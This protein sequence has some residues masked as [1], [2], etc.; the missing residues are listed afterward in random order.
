[1]HGKNRGIIKYV[2]MP[3]VR[4]VSSGRMASPARAGACQYL[5]NNQV[6]CYQ[7]GIQS[8]G[9]PMNAVSKTGTQSPLA[10]VRGPASFQGACVMRN[11]YVLGWSPEFGGTPVGRLVCGLRLVL[12]QIG[13]AHV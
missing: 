11:W 6:S 4:Q 7:D 1:M 5:T 8:T 9:V 13:R 2:H 3:V 12:F 10:E